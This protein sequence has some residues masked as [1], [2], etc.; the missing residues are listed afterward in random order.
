MQTQELSE[1]KIVSM[2]KTVPGVQ[3]ILRQAE[4]KEA[5]TA[6]RA[7]DVR[8]YH[9]LNK[10]K[11]EADRRREVESAKIGAKIKSRREALEATKKE[12]EAL[13]RECTAQRNVYETRRGELEHRL[14]QSAPEEWKARLEEIQ[15][16]IDRLSKNRYKADEIDLKHNRAL[17]PEMDAANIRMTE[18]L[19]ERDQINKD[20]LEKE[21]GENE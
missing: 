14:R 13:E 8:E 17:S 19:K 21:G 2:L 1:S 9:E 7:D 20:I 11:R 4:Q 15:D 3:A 12:G 18:L 6:S 16:E 10:A 5:L